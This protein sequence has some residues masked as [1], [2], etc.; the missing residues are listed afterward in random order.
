MHAY[1]LKISAR[2]NY[3]CAHVV[4]VFGTITNE[5]DSSSTHDFYMDVHREYTRS[6][7]S[8]NM[9]H[10]LLMDTTSKKI[11]IPALTDQDFLMNGVLYET[12]NIHT[13]SM[14]F[15]HIYLLLYNY[16]TRQ[17]F[18]MIFLP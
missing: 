14:G 2:E 1:K 11:L 3:D 10:V 7:L 8:N 6:V 16:S 9:A 18:S 17:Y 15:V 13:S 5:Y 12:N 4:R